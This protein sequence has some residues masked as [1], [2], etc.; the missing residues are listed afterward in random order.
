MLSDGDYLYMIGK[1]VN[2]TEKIKEEDCK[3]NIK[4]KFREKIA[5][6]ISKDKHK[7]NDEG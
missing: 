5:K 3:K 1:K 4:Q 2:M 7:K 6:K